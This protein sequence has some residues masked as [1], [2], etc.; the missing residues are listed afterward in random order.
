MTATHD[1]VT[2]VPVGE[3]HSQ[4]VWTMDDIGYE[5]EQIPQATLPIGRQQPVTSAAVRS[6]S[7]VRQ[8]GS[9]GEM[10]LSELL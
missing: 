9:I 3:S 2:S 6:L 10:A 8:N 1:S 7:S 4:Q 5:T